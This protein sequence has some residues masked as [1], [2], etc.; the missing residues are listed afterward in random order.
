MRVC[1]V[2]HSAN[3]EGADR[4]LVETVRLLRERGT[5]VHVLVPGHG[6][7]LATLDRFAIP[8]TVC[9][10]GWWLRHRRE[11]PRRRAASLRFLDRNTDTCVFNS[12]AVA[13]RFAAEIVRPARAVV[14]QAVTLEPPPAAKGGPRR[15]GKPLAALVLGRVQ[16]SKGQHTA[17]EA[18]A[19]AR[20]RGVDIDL[21]IVGGGDPLYVHEL[22]ALAES[23]GVADL[24]TFRGFDAAPLKHVVA[25]DVVL[26]CSRQEAF[27]RVT[28]EAMK[29]GR[30]VIGSASGGTTE[31]I[32]DGRTGWLFAPGDAS[33]L[34]SK[35]VMAD[36]DR[37]RLERMGEDGRTWAEATFSQ[38]RY[39]DRMFEILSDAARRSEG[40]AGAG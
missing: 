10:F 19:K 37:S 4:S 8:Y 25:S 39:G 15:P 12:H 29:M 2:A 31:L 9:S 18:V 21:T 16:A 11:S 5:D 33:D 20:A 32:E 7:L 22:G 27:G 6:S 23:L 13:R 40:F 14:Y 26:V 3:M 28:I 24:V 38:D 17:I 36:L 34:A 30:P 1:V 35:L